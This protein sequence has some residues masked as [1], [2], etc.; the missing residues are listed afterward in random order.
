MNNEDFHI[1]ANYDLKE[2]QP[3]A[4]IG[5]FFMGIVGVILSILLIIIKFS[6]NLPVFFQVN[7]FNFWDLLFLIFLFFIAFIGIFLSHEF[8]HAIAAWIFHIPTKFGW[9]RMG[10][11][12]PYLS[13]SLE[14]PVPR[15]QYIW[16]EVMPNLI[17]NVFLA[18]PILITEGQILVFLFV[19]LLI[20]HIEGGG[21]DAAL[22]YAV[23]KYP[24][25]ILVND[26]GH[27]LQILSKDDLEKQPLINQD[28]PIVR[29]IRENRKIFYFL[30]LFFV[31]LFLQIVMA[32]I[33]DLI[34]AAI[35]GDDPNFFKMIEE[36]S[37]SN[38]TIRVNLINCLAFSI[39]L[40]PIIW[41][42]IRKAK[43]KISKKEFQK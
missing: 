22:L 24:S 12:L 29:A 23:F 41:I 1:V 30:P 31:V 5:I 42:I 19:I 4:W 43:V 37:E 21:G 10:K 39:I 9:G 6:L 32:P 16:F 14:K 26:L 11:L 7:Q 8:L 15:H 27:Q 25:T 3:V 18:I 17:I 36:T 28:S 13:V 38:F 33:F 40:T 2:L 20:M 34:L 35:L